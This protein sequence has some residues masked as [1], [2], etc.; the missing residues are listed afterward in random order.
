MRRLRAG[1][2]GDPLDI[3]LQGY[4]ASARRAV[5]KALD[6]T[7]R[8]RRAGGRHTTREMFKGLRGIHVLLERVH[9]T[10]PAQISEPDLFPES[11]HEWVGHVQ[12][13]VRTANR[14]LYRAGAQLEAAEQLFGKAGATFAQVE[15]AQL[16]DVEGQL[17]EVEGLLAKFRGLR[18]SVPSPE[19]IRR[20]A[21]I[22]VPELTGVSESD[23]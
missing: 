16:A 23:G 1:L 9:S 10:V 8:A 18:V 5:G 19:E 11:M 2:Q 21:R 7:H 3:E 14:D 6:V 12:R 13:M 17:H 20:R 4:L 22:T 15:L